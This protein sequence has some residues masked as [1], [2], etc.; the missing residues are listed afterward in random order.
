MLSTRAMKKLSEKQK[1][2]Q[3]QSRVIVEK[4]KESKE[5]MAAVKALKEEKIVNKSM[6]LI[7]ITDH[8]MQLPVMMSKNTLRVVKSGIGFHIK[9]RKLKR[10]YGEADRRKEKKG[11]SD[12]LR[13]KDKEIMSAAEKL[14]EEVLAHAEIAKRLE[15]SGVLLTRTMKKLSE[16]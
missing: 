16:K 4:E 9:S 2:I 13:T 3:E 6:S 15:E 12:A 1:L 7:S 10:S 11:S 5:N 14:E 8:L